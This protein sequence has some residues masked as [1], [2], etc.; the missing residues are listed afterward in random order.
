MKRKIKRLIKSENG[1]VIALV[2]IAFAVFMGFVAMVTDVGILY[3]KQNR[4]KSALDAAA[5]A[6]AQEL[7]GNPSYAVSSAKNYAQLNGLNPT[8]VNI[9]L[10]GDNKSI[11]VTSSQD[12]NL[13]FGRFLGKSSSTVSG[14]AKAK[15]AAV[16]SV[17]G[18]VPFSVEKQTLE[19]G[20]EYVLK[21][22]AGGVSTGD[23]RWHG[24]FGALDFTGGGGGANEYRQ[25]IKSGYSGTV[26][27]GDIIHTESGNMSGPTCDGVD[28]RIGLCRGQ[29]SPECTW[30]NYK[31][32][33]PRIVYI[34]I[35]ESIDKFHVKVVGFGV[36]FL[37]C[38]EGNGNNNDVVG[39]FLKE[40]T[41]ADCDDSLTNYGLNGVKL[42]E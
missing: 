7:P 23:G 5:L 33:C 41:S 16:K 19:Y 21:E 14:S 18:A 42:T 20:E 11:T 10:A 38:V 8:E 29:H 2:A 4:I 12:V 40:T 1:S 25:T 27:V 3:V 17:S 32:D 6:G 22:G 37:K 26:S 9:S 36:F 13:I 39:Y 30:D 24:W 35:V 31:R 34:P 28:Y 15:V